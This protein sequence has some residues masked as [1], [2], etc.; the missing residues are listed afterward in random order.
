MND[1]TFWPQLRGICS[2]S[3][4]ISRY[5]RYLLLPKRLRLSPSVSSQTFVGL[6]IDDLDVQVWIRFATLLFPFLASPQ[7]WWDFPWN[8]Y[9]AFYEL[10]FT[11][12][13]L[14][15]RTEKECHFMG[16]MLHFNGRLNTVQFYNIIS[17]LRNGTYFTWQSLRDFLRLMNKARDPS[18][19]PARLL[20]AS[21]NYH[22]PSSQ[23][24]APN[25]LPSPYNF[26]FSSIR[27]FCPLFLF[28]GSARFCV[29]YDRRFFVFIWWK[30][31]VPFPCSTDRT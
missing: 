1:L 23:F 12:E 4:N 30:S 24:L 9:P 8:F 20:R 7:P 16:R 2:I 27:T 26:L 15:T 18:D 10:R 31:F 17:K 14:H 21:K 6:S 11:P 13:K 19:S 28:P 22:I 3:E 25:P 5:G 29:A